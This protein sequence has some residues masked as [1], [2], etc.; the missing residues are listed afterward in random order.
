M[1]IT[2]FGFMARNVSA[3]ASVAATSGAPCRR[4]STLSKCMMRAITLL[5]IAPGLRGLEP[6]EPLLNV[7]QSHSPREALDELGQFSRP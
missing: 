7:M 4:A 2:P 1:T 3:S 5:L 6:L